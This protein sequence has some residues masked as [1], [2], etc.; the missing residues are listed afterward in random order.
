MEAMFQHLVESLPR[1]F[2][3]LNIFF[4]VGKHFTLTITMFNS[5]PQVAMYH[6]AIK[7]TVDRPR[8]PHREYTHTHTN[9]SNPPR[10]AGCVYLYLRCSLPWCV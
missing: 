6:R 4:S 8:E 5:S 1:R 2:V 9:P 10:S 7:V 3:C